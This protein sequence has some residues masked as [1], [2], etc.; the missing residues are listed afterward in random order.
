VKTA[1]SIPDDVFEEAEETAAALR[2]SRSEFY[3][4]AVREYLKTRRAA[5]VTASYDAAFADVDDEDGELQRRA[6]RKALL[7]VEWNEK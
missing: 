1:I 4:Q 2:I 5:N 3:T 7:D 6:A